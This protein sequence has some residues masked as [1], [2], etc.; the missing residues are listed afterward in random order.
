M[1]LLSHHL[2]EDVG[3]EPNRQDTSKV[4]E[5]LGVPNKSLFEGF[6]VD[7]LLIEGAEYGLDRLPP[8]DSVLF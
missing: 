4:D 6:W 1:S 3:F 7:A 5:G 8:R 2:L